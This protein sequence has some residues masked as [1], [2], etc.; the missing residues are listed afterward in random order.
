MHLVGAIQFQ[1]VELEAMQ[2]L[3]TYSAQLQ[4]CRQIQHL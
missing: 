4:V 3:A 2:H 1:G